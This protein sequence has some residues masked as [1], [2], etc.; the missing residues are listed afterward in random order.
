MF[1]AT[2]Q[3][4]ERLLRER[5]GHRR[6]HRSSGRPVRS[7]AATS[8]GCRSWRRDALEHCARRATAPTVRCTSSPRRFSPAASGCRRGWAVHGTT[9]Y[10]FLN[11]L[12][13]LF[14]DAAQAR[15]MRRVYAQADRAHR[16]V[17][18]RAVREQAAD[19]GHR[20]GERAERA[21]RTCS[22]RISES[23]R[24]SRDFTL[25]S[26]RD[27]I[28]EVVACFPVYRTYV[29]DARL[30]AGGPRGRRPRDRARA[31]AQSGDGIV[32]L[33]L[34]PRGRAAARPRRGRRQPPPSAASGYPPADATEARERLRFAMKL[35]QYTGPV[36]AKGLE[37]T[38]FY[39]YNVLL[40]LNEVGGDP[41]RFGRSVGGVPR[42]ERSCGGATGRSRCWP[43]STHD[44]KLGEDVRARINVLSEMPDEWGR[45]VARWMRL[46]RGAAR[47][48][49]TASRRPIATTSTAS[50]RRWSA[51]WPLEAD[52]VEPR[53]RISSSGCRRT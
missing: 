14:V 38:A 3:L 49:S 34:L 31:A 20:D 51:C 1:A 33:R 27:V 32:D 16:G 29:D 7:G 41:A 40:S 37:D 17:R 47:R 5:H 25:N 21:R 35:Q 26:L 4:L 52:G 53:R 12:N 13:G 19:H 9:G 18:R 42:I 30:D 24:K 43:P 10:N 45:E 39:R 36:Q 23:N 15:R 8:R 44:T 11:E 46:N 22:N 28:I 2:H 6:P 48:S 50:T